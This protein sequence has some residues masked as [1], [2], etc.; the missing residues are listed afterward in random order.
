MVAWLIVFFMKY[1]FYIGAISFM[2]A[3]LLASSL[4]DDLF[5]LKRKKKSPVAQSVEHSAVNRRVV[6]S[7]PTRGATSKKASKPVVSEYS[8]QFK[9]PPN[10]FE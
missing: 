4:F 7:S 3:G 2:L 9:L 8:E 10:P 1:L 5:S 6:G